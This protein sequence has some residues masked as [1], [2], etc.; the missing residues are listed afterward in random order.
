MGKY[1]IEEE[2]VV[3]KSGLQTVFYK[4][5]DENK[6][7]IFMTSNPL[8]IDTEIK[9]LESEELYKNNILPDRRQ[10]RRFLYYSRKTVRQCV[11]LRLLEKVR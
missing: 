5:L 9:K 7:Q 10:H 2:V 1:F 11:V 6:K 4:L 3:C 8:L